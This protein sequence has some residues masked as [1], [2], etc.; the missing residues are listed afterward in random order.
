MLL[1]QDLARARHASRQGDAQRAHRLVVVLTARRAARR[2]RA[3]RERAR[4]AA[5]ASD[6]A[7]LRLAEVR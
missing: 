2:E 3:A 6:F 7:A 5:A 4:H 1:H